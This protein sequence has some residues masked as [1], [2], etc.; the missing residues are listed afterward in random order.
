MTRAGLFDLQTSSDLLKK[1]KHDFQRLNHDQLDQYAAFDFF[2]TAEHIID[3]LPPVED[4]NHRDLRKT[5]PL[6]RICSHIANGSKHFKVNPKRHDSVKST[7]HHQGTFSSGFSEAFDISCLEIHLSDEEV[8]RLE[9]QGI[10]LDKELEVTVLAK[11]ILD[12]WEKY[13]HIS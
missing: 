4:V 12:Y 3:W 9:V 5:E 1:L 6:I 13:P 11:M 2:V 7:G 10:A 8:N